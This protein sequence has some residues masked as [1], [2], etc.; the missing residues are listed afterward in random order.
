MGETGARY[1]GTNDV[2][3]VVEAAATKACALMARGLLVMLCVARLDDEDMGA[4]GGVE[5]VAATARR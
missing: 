1:A 4:G 5:Q 3:G 2:C